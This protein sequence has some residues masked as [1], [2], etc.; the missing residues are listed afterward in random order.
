MV[1]KSLRASHQEL[2]I[3]VVAVGAIAASTDHRW[4]PSRPV[5]RWPPTARPK[6]AA[7]QSQGA[8][9]PSSTAAG[10]PL[11][12]HHEKRLKANFEKRLYRPE[13]PGGRR[14]RP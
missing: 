6:A 4:P 3:A 1:M 2:V 8:P 13:E 14:R 10:P 11:S 7:E 5:R 9:G 12:L